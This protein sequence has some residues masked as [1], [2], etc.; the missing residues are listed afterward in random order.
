[1]LEIWHID[2]GKW[3]TNEIAEV[4][5]STAYPRIAISTVAEERVKGEVG[6]TM[7]VFGDMAFFLAVLLDA[8][9][10]CFAG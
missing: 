5:G 9:P 8:C 2:G 10:A 6:A 4:R 1:M 3:P 7:P